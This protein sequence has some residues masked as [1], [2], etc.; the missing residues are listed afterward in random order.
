MLVK[1]EEAKPYISS[2]I[3]PRCARLLRR[4]HRA[5]KMH[6][7][8]PGLSLLHGQTFRS[9]MTSAGQ[10]GSKSSLE[11][12]NFCL[13]MSLKSMTRTCFTLG[14]LPPR[15]TQMC[16]QEEAYPLKQK[17]QYPNFKCQVIRQTCTFSF[18]ATQTIT[19]TMNQNCSLKSLRMMNKS[20]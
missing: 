3:L 15:E 5:V 1:R 11:G 16:H 20:I 4:L 9:F 6:S 2:V 8:R 12:F 17:F 19:K 18:L 10:E 7:L 13:E 14:F